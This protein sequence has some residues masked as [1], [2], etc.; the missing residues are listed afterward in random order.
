MGF[1]FVVVYYGNTGSSWLMETLSTT[2]E[3]L[4]PG[5][6]P[7]EAWA[8]KVSDAEKLA[9]VRAALQPPT[10]RWGEPFDRWVAELAASPQ[11]QEI[12]GWKRDNFKVLGFKMSTSAVADSTA[13]IEVVAEAGARLVALRRDDRL[14]HALSLYRYHEERRSQF[15]GSE[16]GG[17]SRVRLRRFQRWVDESIRL[18]EGLKTFQRLAVEQLGTER[19]LPVGYEEFVTSHGKQA[20]IDRLAQFLAL[21][22]GLIKEAAS[23]VKATPD[24]LSEAVANYQ[25]LRRRYRSTPLARSFDP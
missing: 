1:S 6:E 2:K 20:T 19:V 4:V 24:D 8:W 17:P 23:F 7:L 22:R 11:F 5:F 15:A 25:A 10:Q 9:W 3:V 16:P 13:L 18:D 21:D 14:R 12:V